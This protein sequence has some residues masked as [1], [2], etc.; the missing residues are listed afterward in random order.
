[1]V[2]LLGSGASSA[3]RRISLGIGEAVDDSPGLRRVVH[4]PDARVAV[5]QEQ[6]EVPL[7]VV[8]EAV[9]PDG[10]RTAHRMH[11][12]VPHTGDQVAARRIDHVHSR[13]D[14]DLVARADREDNVA[15]AYRF[16]RNQTALWSS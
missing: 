8:H 14:P 11:V 7:H 10:F 4:V 12:H 1:M 13:R 9:Y 16:P 6:R 15:S 2:D 5:G 3:S